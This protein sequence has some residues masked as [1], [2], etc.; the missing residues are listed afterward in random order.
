MAY[1]SGIYS[2]ENLSFLISCNANMVCFVFPVPFAF[3]LNSFRNHFE[4][5]RYFHGPLAEGHWI[6]DME[7][8]SF[9][10]SLAIHCSV[11]SVLSLLV[12]LGQGS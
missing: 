4:N 1:F 7:S 10:Y 9:I 11:Y 12:T 5:G 8:A 6:H 2:N 3:L